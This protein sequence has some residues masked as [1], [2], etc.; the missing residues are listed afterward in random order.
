MREVQRFESSTAHHAF[1]SPQAIAGFLFDKFSGKFRVA[2]FPALARYVHEQEAV[3]MLKH[4][5]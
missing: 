4:V 3:D 2:H 1:V 5:I